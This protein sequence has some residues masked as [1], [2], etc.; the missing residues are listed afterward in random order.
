MGFLF[1]NLTFLS[2]SLAA[3]KVK[4]TTGSRMVKGAADVLPIPYGSIMREETEKDQKHGPGIFGSAVSS[5]SCFQIFR[6]CDVLPEYLIRL[7]WISS[8]FSS[9]KLEQSHRLPK[10]KPIL[11]VNTESV[12]ACIR[13]KILEEIER[14]G[15]I[16]CFLLRP[17][18]RIKRA[19]LLT[20]HNPFYSL[21]RRPQS[22][23][24]DA[25]TRKS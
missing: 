12:R 3:A 25:R 19:S 11:S 24:L 22:H 1:M 8:D 2:K 20:F 10:A 15:L 17:C 6:P 21:S 9:R 16:S 14:V 5:S 7:S 23:L 4:E 13:E 18:A